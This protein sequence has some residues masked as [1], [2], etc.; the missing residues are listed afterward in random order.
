[1][2][3]DTS[4]TAMQV[5]GSDGLERLK[6]KVIE[7]GPAPLYQG[8]LASAAATA[9]GHLY[10]HIYHLLFYAQ[11]TLCST[12]ISSSMIQSMVFDIQFSGELGHE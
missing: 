9:A 8:A 12:S 10:V 2:P 5:E 6:Q 4:K 7:S 3:I 1:M 11:H